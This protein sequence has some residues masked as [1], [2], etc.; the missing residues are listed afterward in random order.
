MNKLNL[1][2]VFIFFW[3]PDLCMAGQEMS[4]EEAKSIP[5]DLIWN[6]EK[7]NPT[8]GQIKYTEELLKLNLIKIPKRKSFKS[9]KLSYIEKGVIPCI[10]KNKWKD[11][12]TA[13]PVT[14]LYTPSEGIKRGLVSVSTGLW[15]E[16]TYNYPVSEISFFGLINLYKPK[17]FDRYYEESPVR[18]KGDLFSPIEDSGFT[19]GY[20]SRSWPEGVDND[21]SPRSRGDHGSIHACTWGHTEDG[22]N[23]GVP[24]K[25]TSLN[26]EIKY[27]GVESIYHELIS[28]LYLHD[29]ALF[30]PGPDGRVTGLSKLLREGYKVRIN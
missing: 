27:R 13:Y 17:W 11:V 29:Y 1:F 8:Q 20:A 30:I 23:F 6:N 12:A 14:V 3:I 21:S 19:I 15:K 9:I 28:Y 16:A 22:A 7:S 10:E 26:C 4:C 25:V 24:G 18:I 2:V 5:K